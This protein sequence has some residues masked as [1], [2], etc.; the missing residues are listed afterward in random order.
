MQNTQQIPESRKCEP[1]KYAYK[2]LSYSEEFEVIQSLRK[3]KVFCD[4]KLV[5]VDD[6][7]LFAHKVVLASASPYFHAKFTKCSERNHIVM[8]QL[9]S[10][11]L[12]LSVNFIYSGE[13]VVT[14]EN[15][16]A[17]LAAASLLQ[18][19]EV[20][21][22][23]CDFLNSQLRPTNCIGIT[24]IADKYSCTKLLTSSEL[25]IQDH[26]S[27][28]VDG[29]EFTSLSPE[30]VVELISSDKITVPSEEKVFECVIRW[31]KHELDSRKC[32]LPQLMEHVRLPLTS[33]HYILKKVAEEPL[34]KNCLKCTDYVMEALNF[35]ILNSEELIP[36]N[37]RN[38]PRHG[39]K[40]IL[41]V[42][43]DNVINESIFGKRTGYNFIAINTTEW[44]D[45]KINQCLNG[46]EMIKR[47]RGAG[48][49]VVNENF[50]FA[51][52]GV[53][54]FSTF[55]RSVEILD[56]SSESP[57]W[58]SSVHML[59]ERNFPGV[60]VINNYLYAVGGHNKSDSAL[61]SAEVFD[62]NTQEWRMV[63]SM[64]TKR[65]DFGVGVLNNLLYAV[66]GCDKPFQALDIVECYHPSLDTWTT[67]AKMS[68]RRSQVGI[69]VLDGVL[70]AV[71]GC[72]G[73]KTLSSVEAYRPSTGVWTT[74]VD[75]H[76]PRRRAGVVALNGLLYVVGTR[77][78]NE[79]STEN[80]TEYYNPKTN[81]WTMVTASMNYNR[82][83]VGVVAINRPQYLKKC[84]HS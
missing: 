10:T 65:Y 28:V 73:S 79:T 47:C 14:E 21:E 83:P 81:T 27:E 40:L 36:Q 13:I 50:V 4:I 56:L 45:P 34:I 80:C 9:D 25:Y 75:M 46:P 39:D 55:L 67:V 15:V 70:Y 58:K 41:V 62:Y 1:A 84:Q 24:A 77:G 29:D 43:H 72:D 19:R 37:V 51:V 17:L 48:L 38:T 54:S 33:K 35:H 8:K 63:S 7:I 78:Q 11:A 71:G 18:L 6:K 68:V 3:D 60:G 52:G 22:A 32:I 76:L 16:Q 5:T 66:G 53:E 26:F 49:A 69:G 44:F 59:V 23:C 20:K 74:I 64:C 82:N 31:V 61:D 30:Q 12:E 57:S 42:G 2:K